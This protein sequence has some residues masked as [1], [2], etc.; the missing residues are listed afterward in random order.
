MSTLW[1]VKFDY[2][3]FERG[4]AYRHWLSRYAMPG[5]TASAP[6]L[7]AKSKIL[8]LET[9]EGPM[10]ITAIPCHLCLDDVCD[11]FYWRIVDL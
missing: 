3:L 1:A 6:I 4:A 10:S 9:S 8:G 7:T 2:R 11:F 5:G